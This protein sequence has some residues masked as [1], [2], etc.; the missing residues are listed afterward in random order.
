MLFSML[1]ITPKMFDKFYVPS[2]LETE[3]KLLKLHQS[4][5]LIITV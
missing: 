3:R 1:F 4:E 5:F 2:F